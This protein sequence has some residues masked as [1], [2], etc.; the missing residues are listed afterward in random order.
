[1]SDDELTTIDPDQLSRAHGGEGWLSRGWNVV[2]ETFGYAGPAGASEAAAAIPAAAGAA[3][4]VPQG[5]ARNNLINTLANPTSSNRQIDGAFNRYHN[6]PGQ[7]LLK[8]I[9]GG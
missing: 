3:M 8:H 1:M 6:G 9:P 2:K 4:L 7:K 5:R